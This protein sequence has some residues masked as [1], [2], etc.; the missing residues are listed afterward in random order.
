MSNFDVYGAYAMHMTFDGHETHDTF[1]AHDTHIHM[2]HMMQLPLMVRMTHVLDAHDA[3][4][5]KMSNEYDI[6]DGN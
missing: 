4:L 1:N 5:T 3:Y 6:L 2:R